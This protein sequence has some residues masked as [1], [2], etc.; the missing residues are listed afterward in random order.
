MKNIHMIAAL[1]AMLTP[2]M[3]WGASY[4]STIT[5]EATPSAGGQ[6][7]VN[8]SQS[9]SGATYAVTSSK[10]DTKSSAGIGSWILIHAQFNFYLYAK[11]TDSPKF[12]FEGWS[13]S[14]GGSI[15][16]TDNPYNVSFQDQSLTKTY[17]A[18]FKR[19]YEVT[20][21]AP[22]VSAGFA[23]YAVSGKGISGSGPSSGG[24]VEVLEGETYTFT[25]TLKNTDIYE[26]AGWDVLKI[27]F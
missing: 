6:V 4:T 10:S 25:C 13:E 22:T 24:T 20:L 9:D 21:V 11:Q 5:A 19:K 14:V 18:N 1:L 3:L 12:V 15:V 27:Q 17:Y 26:F 8:T 2:T 23:S 16:S 7:F